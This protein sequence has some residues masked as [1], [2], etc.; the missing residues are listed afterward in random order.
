MAG[1][2]FELLN[3]LSMEKIAKNQKP[4]LFLM[5]KSRL[6]SDFRRTVKISELAEEYNVSVITIE[7]MFK[8]ELN[9]TPAK[10]RIISKMNHAEE[11]LKHSSLSIKEIAYELGYCH[12][13]HFSNEFRR[14]SGAFAR[15][16]P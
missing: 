4:L 2:T 10:F 5:L 11:L 6:S 13:F 16:V 3:R 7:R 8:K 12:Q 9:I 1:M 15:S 14:I